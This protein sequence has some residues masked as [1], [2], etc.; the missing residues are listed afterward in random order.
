MR[1]NTWDVRFC[2]PGEDEDCV[3]LVFYLSNIL[4]ELGLRCFLQASIAA[5]GLLLL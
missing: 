4:A 1:L 5:R 2:K 3:H